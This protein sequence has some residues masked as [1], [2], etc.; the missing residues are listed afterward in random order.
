M[1]IVSFLKLFIEALTLL[2]YLEA[3]LAFTVGA[4][5]MMTVDLT[6]P[7]VESGVW[8]RGSFNS[9]LFKTGII[10]ALGMSLHNFPEGLVVSAGYIHIP[11]LGLLIAIMICLHNIPE[12]IATTTPLALAGIGKRKALTLAF[13]S[14]LTEPLGALVGTTILST[15]GGSEH[16]IGLGLAIAA[17][18]MTYITVDELIPVAH[19]YSTSRS[20]HVVSTGLLLGM[21]FAQLITL[22]LKAY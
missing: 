19:E 17:G 18:V 10:I 16:I 12:G 3:S 1:L 4:L 7:H 8:E 5:F 22:A 15:L 20:K 13:L 6:L 21:I 9:E 2:S 11:K 14:G